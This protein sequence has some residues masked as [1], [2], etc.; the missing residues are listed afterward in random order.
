MLARCCACSSRR[1]FP[2]F[3]GVL[4]L[5]CFPTNVIISRAR[6]RQVTVQSLLEGGEE[7]WWPALI[8]ALIHTGKEEWHHGSLKAGWRPWLL[9]KSGPAAR[10]QTGSRTS[11]SVASWIF[12]GHWLYTSPS[13]LRVF[14]EM[15]NCVAVFSVTQNQGAPGLHSAL[16][17]H[18]QWGAVE[19]AFGNEVSKCLTLSKCACLLW[20]DHLWKG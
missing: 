10:P 12:W 15:L 17:G 4:G 14:K 13:Q 18:I 8:L 6:G 19:G 2:N 9:S 3:Y 16:P 7:L 1:G 5:F 11:W 20:F